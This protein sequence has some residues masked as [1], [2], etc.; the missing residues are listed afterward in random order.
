LAVVGGRAKTLLFWGMART[1]KNI[2]KQGLGRFQALA[3][4]PKKLALANIVLH[5]CSTMR[6]TTVRELRNHYSKVL[7]WVSAGEEVQVTRR[8][9]VVA[10]VVPPQPVSSGKL[11]WTE[12]TAFRRSDWPR[13][14]SAAE[15]AAVLA[16]SQGA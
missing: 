11:D 15:S 6:T 7:R 14:L 8:G 3:A 12:S 4:A 1:S 9:K 16:D 2:V 13:E 10:R 5:D